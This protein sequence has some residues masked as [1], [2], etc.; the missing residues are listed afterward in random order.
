MRETTCAG[1]RHGVHNPLTA[2]YNFVHIFNG[3]TPWRLRV[4]KHL[5]LAQQFTK[6]TTI[7]SVPLFT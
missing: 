5:I 3:H 7:I 4:H 2:Q 1:T 6:F